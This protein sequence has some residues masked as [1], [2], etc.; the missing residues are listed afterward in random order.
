MLEGRKFC[1]FSD[2]KPLTFA[3]HRMSDTWS[4]HQKRHLSY[5]AEYTSDIR[6][7]P[8]KNN[9][10]AD[11]LSRPADAVAPATGGVDY[12]RLA[13]AQKVCQETA[14]L[15]TC[16]SLHVQSVAVNNVELFCDTSNGLIRPL[17]PAE[18]RQAV[19]KSIHQLAHP[20]TRPRGE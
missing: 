3:L 5:V 12:R 2:H 15:S 20:G 6:H 16:Q 10:M 8:G 11:A 1:I 18:F 19:Y 13:A 4:A 17:V 9:T 7:V 14:E